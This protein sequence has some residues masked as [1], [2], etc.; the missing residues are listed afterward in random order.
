MH[1]VG[2]SDCDHEALEEEKAVFE[3]NGIAFVLHQCR[4]EDEL[5]RELQEYE[6]I[7]NQYAPLTEKVFRGLPRLKCVVRYGVGVDNIEL[8]AAT[9]HGVKICNVP[10]YGVQ[11]V[12]GH[13]AAFML[14]LSRKIVPM[15]SGVK[16][17][18]WN[19]EASIPITRFNRMVVGIIGLGRIGKCFAGIVRGLDCRIIAYDSKDK[20]CSGKI[21]DNY[22]E[23]VSFPRLLKTADVVSVHTPLE[24]SRGLIGEKE[25][26]LMKTT[27]YLINVSRGGIIDEEA[28]EKALANKWIAGAACD[29]FEKEPPAGTPLF[30]HENF[31]ATPHMAWYSEQASR[32]LKTKLAEEMTRACYGLPLKYQLNWPV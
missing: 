31:I 27:A 16:R 10:D 28:L 18:R 14:A 23:V 12:A 5:I 21:I 13:A 29:V 32:E 25:L 8:E 3:K 11:E 26:R 22:I 17:G 4:T 15:N 7:G 19:Y 24:S 1:R 20:G 9:R 30:K 2:I 6:V